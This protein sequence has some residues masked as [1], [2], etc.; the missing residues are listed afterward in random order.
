M[1]E[2]VINILPSVGNEMDAIIR[3]QQHLGLSYHTPGENA[4]ARAGRPE[5]RGAAIAGRICRPR[6][7][8]DGAGGL[9]SGKEEIDC[10]FWAVWL[11]RKFLKNKNKT[12]GP[13]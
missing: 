2:T 5:S 3:Y 12:L 9:I 4:I 13:A 10:I 7:S 11:K 6:P 1:I 8:P